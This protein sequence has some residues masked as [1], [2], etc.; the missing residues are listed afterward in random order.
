MLSSVVQQQ[1][2]EGYRQTEIGV[3]PRDWELVHLGSLV[4]P[5]R[6]IRYGVVQPGKRDPAG[7][8]M[9]RSQDYSKGWCGTD[10][11]H[12]IGKTLEVQFDG[13]RL[14]KGDLVITLVGAGV[15]QIVEIPRWIE[16]AI[17][18]R[19]TGRIAID[20]SKAVNQYVLHFMS[21]YL[22]RNQVL[23]NIKEGAQPVV[24]SLDVGACLV[25]RPSIKEQAAIANA[26][27]DVDALITSLE[28][29]IAKKRGIKTAAMQQLLTGKKRL[30]PFDQAHTGYKQT[31]L[32][33]IPEDWEEGFFGDYLEY[34]SSGATPYR[35]RPEFYKGNVRWVSSGELNY[36]VIY[37]TIEKVSDEAVKKTNLKV[38][39][40]GTFLMAITGLEAAGTRGSC[41]ILGAPSTTNQSC[42]A[43]YPNNK[44]SMKF[45]FHYYVYMGDELA[46]K[47]CQGTKQQSYT[48]KIVK[49]LPI[50]IP[51]TIE[52]Q[53]AIAEMLFEMDGEAE[54]L[55]RRLNKT[56]QLKQ[57]MMQEL[58]TGRTRLV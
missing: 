40:A 39:P 16:G 2:P 17:L 48:A 51:G 10:G 4:D 23:F 44:L 30:P 7:C 27:S 18:S 57:G 34:C 19:S 5:S 24:S 6:H 15:A 29:L 52:E 22:G 54:I 36:N 21:S 33:E 13:A 46:F 41:G 28:K 20:P 12:R 42:M 56:Q 38:H 47:Y 50:N 26:L 25:P 1:V 11:M 31:E 37:D 53:D 58:L 49:L 3:I 32:G 45:L 35:G 55:E 8:L 43:L 9:L 14:A